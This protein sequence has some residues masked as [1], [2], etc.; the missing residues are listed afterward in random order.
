VKIKI[1]RKNKIYKTEMLKGILI[2]EIKK[3]EEISKKYFYN[4]SGLLT[5]FD[6]TAVTIAPGEAIKK[7]T[8]HIVSKEELDVILEDI[9]AAKAEKLAE[10]LATKE[11]EK[12]EI[13]IN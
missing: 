2:P 1:G 13:I 4:E 5:I 12:E 11:A 3:D 8:G 10:K 7:R 6:V 9:E